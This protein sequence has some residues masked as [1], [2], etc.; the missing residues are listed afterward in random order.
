MLPY[1]Y[2]HVTAQSPAPGGVALRHGM[3]SSSCHRIVLATAPGVPTPQH[4][5]P[6]PQK[7]AAGFQLAFSRTG[8]Q[9]VCCSPLP[10]VRFG[11]EHN[12][13]S[14][15]THHRSSQ[16]CTCRPAVAMNKCLGNGNLNRQFET[17]SESNE[18]CTSGLISAQCHR[19]QNIFC[20]FSEGNMA[21]GTY[22]M[23]CTSYMCVYAST[24]YAAARAVRGARGIVW[25]GGIIC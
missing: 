5:F 1:V 16:D 14:L 10:V 21:I 12:V 13:L 11:G 20:Q 4:R 25:S 9:T 23:L 15:H 7:L 8:P 24:R 19:H 6:D 17:N 18:V 3:L 2:S 22:Q